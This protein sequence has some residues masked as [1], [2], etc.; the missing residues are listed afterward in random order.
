MSPSVITDEEE[1][2]MQQFPVVRE[3]DS[4]F[5]PLTAMKLSTGKEVRR[6]K[7]QQKQGERSQILISRKKAR[8]HSIGGAKLPL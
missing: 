7:H 8:S 3:R 2:M 1:E 4:E 5:F 6:K